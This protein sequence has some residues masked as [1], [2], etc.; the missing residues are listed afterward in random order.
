MNRVSRKTAAVNRKMGPI[1]RYYLEEFPAC[2]V[3][4][5]PSHCV[6]EIVRGTAGRSI[7][8]TMPSLWLPACASCN[9]GPLHNRGEWPDSAQLALKLLY[10]PKRFSLFDYWA[11]RAP[12]GHPDP[13]QC[14]TERDVLEAV[15]R[16]MLAGNRI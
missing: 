11:A 3:C 16:L 10:D 7:A 13:P 6:H 2:F 15:R 4:F 12:K 5:G 14:V 1:R 8:F 9:Q